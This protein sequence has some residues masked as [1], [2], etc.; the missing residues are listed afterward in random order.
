MEYKP[1]PELPEMKRIT[2]LFVS[3][4]DRKSQVDLGLNPSCDTCDLFAG[5]QTSYA[6]FPH[7]SDGD[8]SIWFMECDKMRYNALWEMANPRLT[9]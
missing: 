6:W 1:Q 9:H 3:C 5:Y 7:L 2:L 8:N 4:C